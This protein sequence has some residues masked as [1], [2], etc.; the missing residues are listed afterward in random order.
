MTRDSGQ[1]AMS[2]SVSQNLK[3]QISNLKSQISNLKPV[4]RNPRRP[5]NFRSLPIV[6]LSPFTFSRVVLDS[7]QTCAIVPL[8]R[9]QGPPGRAALC[10]AGNAGQRSRRARLIR[11]SIGPRRQKR[12]PAP[13]F[14]RRSGGVSVQ[15]CLYLAFRFSL[16]HSVFRP[17]R[18]PLRPPLRPDR[19]RIG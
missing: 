17:T 8:S 19:S 18:R 10:G 6:T 3:S 13:A 11:P 14:A 5:N 12:A 16:L 1:V 2:P 9:R 15:R 4:A 7:S